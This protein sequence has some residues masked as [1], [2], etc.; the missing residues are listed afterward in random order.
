MV[1]IIHVTAGTSLQA[2]AVSRSWLSA[3]A[4]LVLRGASYKGKKGTLARLQ[5][6][7]EN[8]EPLLRLAG[9]H[10]GR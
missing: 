9:S 8:L 3:C 7:G 6:D 4:G 10:R 2:S 1:S 5:T